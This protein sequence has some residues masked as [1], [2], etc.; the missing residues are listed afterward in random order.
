MNKN[1]PLL[2]RIAKILK[3]AYY[4]KFINENVLEISI[5][6]ADMPFCYAMIEESKAPGTV[7]LS[8]AVDFPRAFTAAEIALTCLNEVNTALVE[9]FYTTTTGDRYFGPEAHAHF[10]AEAQSQMLE[11]MEPNSAVLH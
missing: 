5:T 4:V 10:Q 9:E 8:F 7:L 11:Q 1:N 6:K 3:E 2:K